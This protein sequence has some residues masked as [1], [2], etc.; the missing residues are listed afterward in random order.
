[1]RKT[2]VL[3]NHEETLRRKDGTLLH[4][5]QNITAVRDA[6]GRIE[7]IRGLMLDVTEQKTFQAQLQR[8]RDFNQKILNATQ[9]MILV[10]DTAGLISYANR[11]CYEAGLQTGRDLIGHR[12]VDLVDAGQRQDFE[13]ALETTAHGHQ[14][15][16]IELRVRRSD[17]TLGHFSISLSPMR[18]EQNAVN[19]VV[20]VMTDITDAALM[21][22][23]L[24]HCRANG[25]H[26]PAGFRRGA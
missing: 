8:E 25:H 26:R 18:D 13:A 12:L 19:S 6:H 24:A 15:E 16:N 20:V 9:S 23:K 22:A 21:Q 3:R 10:L 1:M 11:R 4:T 14:V 2:G 5:L 7:Q 17:G